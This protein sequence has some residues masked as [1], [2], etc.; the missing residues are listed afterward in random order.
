MKEI[1][2]DINYTNG[3][4]QIS[5]LGRVKHKARFTKNN[6]YI[7]ERILKPMLDKY[8]YCVVHISNYPKQTIL[9]HRLVANAFIPNT[10]NKVEVNHKD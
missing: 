8:G 9:I 10:L 6:V 2:K 4:Y 3:N 1:W 7:N 5:N